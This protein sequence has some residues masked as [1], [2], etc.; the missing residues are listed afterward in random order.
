MSGTKAYDPSALEKASGLRWTEIVAGLDAAGGAALDHAALARVAEDLLTGR[1]D[2]VGWW[3]QGAAVGY[4]QEIGR[5]RPGQRSDGAWSASASKTFP[6]DRDTALAAVEQVFG[7]QERSRGALFGVPF[8][9]EA[10]TSSTEKWRYWRVDLADGSKVS[11]TIGAKA[12][13]KDG[14]EKS[15]IG[16]E[17]AGLPDEG[18]VATRKAELKELL[19][20]VVGLNGR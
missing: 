3:A 5:R 18:S 14:A 19:A 7:G 10:R 1:V 8:A 17:V 15:S 11:V 6:G 13:G 4:E 2:T 12:P 9:G 20:Q 16:V